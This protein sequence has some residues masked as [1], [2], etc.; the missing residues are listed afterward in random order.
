MGASTASAGTLPGRARRFPR[1]ISSF[2]AYGGRYSAPAAYLLAALIITIG[3]LGR[4]T[5][6]LHADDGL[7]YWLG[8]VG[9]IAMLVIPLYSVRKR[10][11]TLQWLGPIRHWFRAHMGLGIFG[12]LVILYHSNFQLGDLNSRIALYCALLVASSGIIGRYLYEHIHLGLYGRRATLADRTQRVRESL[13]RTNNGLF[14][15]LYERLAALDREVLED[16][17]TLSAAVLR[18]VAYAW[19]TRI[20]AWQLNRA[21]AAELDAAARRSPAVAEQR[22]RL[23][24]TAKRHV[25]DHLGQVRAVALFGFYERAF[26][27]WHV[28]HLPFFFLLL[29]S[30]IVHV[31]AVHLY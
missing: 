31:I 14:K 17:D 10:I 18:P 2:F 12:P 8:I 24:H 5:R 21:V 11:R 29:I 23:S 9:G 27:L 16:V 4:D 30:A 22:S 20:I 3:W 19:K 13:E 15:S 28:I 7:G 6:N 1:S 25:R 26:Y